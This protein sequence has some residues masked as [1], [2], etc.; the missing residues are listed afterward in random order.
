MRDASTRPATSSAR[1]PAT[2][3]PTVC[4]AGPD[5]GRN[6]RPQPEADGQLRV[7]AMK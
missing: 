7:C 1:A 3:T 4:A 5:L 6:P 2:I